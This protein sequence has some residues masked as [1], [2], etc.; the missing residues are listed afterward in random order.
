MKVLLILTNT[1]DFYISFYK[2]SGEIVAIK[3][4]DLEGVIILLYK[5]NFSI[6][7]LLN[8]IIQIL[9][10]NVRMPKK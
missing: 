2:K 6:I 8:I 5:L 9:Y 1:D 7:N 3:M 4:I 10:F